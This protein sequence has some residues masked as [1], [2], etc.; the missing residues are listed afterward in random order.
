MD[1]KSKSNKM[2]KAKKWILIIALI[3]M[4]V[5]LLSI[6]VDNLTNLEIN[7]GSYLGALAMFLVAL[8]MYLSKRK[9][10]NNT[11]FKE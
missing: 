10:K 2:E 4:V 1:K 3:L 11:H 9:N 5:N 7:L 8:S 6:D